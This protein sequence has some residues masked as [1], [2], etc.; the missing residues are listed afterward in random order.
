M[1][2][3]VKDQIGGGPRVVISPRDALAHD[4]AMLRHIEPDVQVVTRQPRWEIR[5]R[6]RRDEERQK[7]DRQRAPKDAP[8]RGWLGADPVGGK[9]FHLQSG[10]PQNVKGE[11]SGDVESQ[12]DLHDWNTATVAAVLETCRGDLLIE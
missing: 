2:M 12:F 5:K 1:G 6:E 11:L 8:A 10:L 9:E 3:C 4:H 7:Q